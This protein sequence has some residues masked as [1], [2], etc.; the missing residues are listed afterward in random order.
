MSLNF[1]YDKNILLFC[2]LSI[3]IL[4][5]VFAKGLTLTSVIIP[6]MEVNAGS[7]ALPNPRQHTQDTG[8]L[9]INSD[10]Q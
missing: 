8:F 7:V 4:T 6:T 3:I 2:L 9:T 1:F 10:Y 5:F